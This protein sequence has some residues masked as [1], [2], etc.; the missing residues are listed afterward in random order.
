MFPSRP[1]AGGRKTSYPSGGNYAKAFDDA[2]PTRPARAAALACPPK[3]IRPCGGSWPPLRH[4]MKAPI[5]GRE[6]KLPRRRPALII[7]PLD[8][9]LR[10]LRV[11]Y[12]TRQYLPRHV[13]GTEIPTGWR[14]ARR[15]VHYAHV[16]THARG[17]PGRPA[18]PVPAPHGTRRR[19]CHRNSSQ[20]EPRRRPRARRVRQPPRRRAR[21]PG[22]RSR[23][24]G[25]G[26]R[27][28]KSTRPKTCSPRPPARRAESCSRASPADSPTIS[29]SRRRRPSGLS[30][31]GRWPSA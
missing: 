2:R 7:R 27:R 28:S 18:R 5:F 8:E 12:L 19:P 15:A 17:G 25:R 21:P 11:V 1:S 10:P 14:R 22:T 13:G 23:P 9:G 4:K 31:P 6:F 29:R 30:T 3:M 24:A 16:I 26:P 20:P